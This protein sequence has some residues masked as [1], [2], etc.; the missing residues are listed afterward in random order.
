M[1]RIKSQTMDKCTSYKDNY[2]PR[3]NTPNISHG[4]GQTTLGNFRGYN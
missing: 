2:R 4:H 3:T 1:H